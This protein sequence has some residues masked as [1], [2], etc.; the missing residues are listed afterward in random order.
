MDRPVL[1]IRLVHFLLYEFVHPP[2]TGFIKLNSGGS[3]SQKQGFFLLWYREEGYTYLILI[4]HSTPTNQ[5]CTVSFIRT[6]VMHLLF[7]LL[8]Y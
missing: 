1:L 5:M 2:F 7:I 6:E 4:D 3:Q 8:S